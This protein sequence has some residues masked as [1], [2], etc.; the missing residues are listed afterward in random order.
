MIYADTIAYLYGLQK[1][2]MKFGLDNTRRLMSLLGEPHTSFSSIHVAGTN[3]KGSTSAMIESLLRTKGVRTGLFTSPHLVSFTERI[4]VNG[5]EISEYAVVKLADEVR[6][7]VSGVGDFCPTFFEVVTAIAFLHFMRMKVEWAV[8]EVGMGG[9]LDATNIIQPE[10]AVITSIGIDH[11]EFLGDTLEDIAREKAGIIKQGVPLVT[12]EQCPEVMGVIQQRCDEKE[13][14]LFRFH[15]E[16]SAERAS[17][18][19]AVVSLHYQG[20]NAYRDVSLSLA[21]E[22]QIVNA[23]LAIKVIEIV[24]EKYPEMDG[25][26]REG[27]EA[28]R[29]PGR[30]E[31]IKANPPILID[32]A[33]NPPA[34]MA[35]SAHLQKLLGTKYRRIIMVAGVMADKDIGGIL[36]PL[37]PLASEIIFASP[38]YGRAASAKK[39]GEVAAA[40]GHASKTSESVAG[41]LRMAE[42]LAEPG[43]LIVVTGSFYTLGEAKEAVGQKGILAGLRE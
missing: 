23:A 34:A 1:H 6:K 9:R 40:L 38:A 3:G 8:V 33:H 10:V 31:M 24:S 36:K 25:D 12:A 35:L 16:F 27:L 19:S 29:W 26:I 21:G 18:D 28:V 14:P 17:R 7:V 41:A 11:S 2:G 4:R 13:A 30:L 37:L 22:H 42:S 32:G 20:K 15:S 39:L 43:D 5:E